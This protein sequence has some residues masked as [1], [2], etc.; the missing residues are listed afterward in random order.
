[1]ILFIYFVFNGDNVIHITY[2]YIQP[3]KCKDKLNLPEGDFIYLFIILF[4]MEI[5]LY[6]LTR[7]LSVRIS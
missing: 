2:I 3:I 1:V 5:M 6:I 4:L 7:Q